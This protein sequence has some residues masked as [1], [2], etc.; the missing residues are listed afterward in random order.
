[1]ASAV[2]AAVIVDMLPLLLIWRRKNDWYCFL[3]IWS[4]EAWL[5]MIC[6]III[7]ICG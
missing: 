7:G 6:N 5:G 3:E 1:V 4:L 2:V